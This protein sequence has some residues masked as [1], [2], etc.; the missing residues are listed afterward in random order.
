[1][2]KPGGII[3]FSIKTIIWPRYEE[4]IRRLEETAKLWRREYASE[5]VPNLPAIKEQRKHVHTDMV[6]LYVYRK[7]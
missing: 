7:L 5:S 1:V 2:T 6:V 4:E 3:A